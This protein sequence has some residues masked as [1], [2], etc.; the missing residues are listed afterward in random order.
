VKA[1]F[2]H[3]SFSFRSVAKVQEL[4]PAFN[5]AKDWIRYAPN[6][7]L[8]YTTSTTARWLARLKPYLADNDVVMIIKIP[9]TDLDE[10]I[11]GWLPKW[12]WHWIE[13]TN[14]Q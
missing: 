1:T 12:V 4:E 13:T 8:V 7:W 14:T 5:K 9:P 3:I 6:C 10:N 11:D 2:L